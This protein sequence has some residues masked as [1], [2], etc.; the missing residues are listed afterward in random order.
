MCVCVCVCVCLKDDDARKPVYVK[1]SYIRIPTRTS[2]SIA[3]I[4]F[5]IYITINQVHAFLYLKDDDARKPVEREVRVPM[6]I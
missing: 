1:K 2:R 4:Y 6:S 3:L 5:F